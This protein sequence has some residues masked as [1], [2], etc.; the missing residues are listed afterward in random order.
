VIEGHTEGTFPNGFNCATLLSDEPSVFVQ[1][2]V[3]R[4]M[5]LPMSLHDANVVLRQLATALMAVHDAGICHRDIKPENVM[6]RPDGLLKLIDFGLA[7]L[8][9]ASA[10]VVLTESGTVM[11][12][13]AYMA[14]EQL[15]G[16]E[17]DARSDIWSF[18]VLAEELVG[19][20]SHGSR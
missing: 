3:T 11:G 8:P 6:L 1:A 14:P 5:E 17:T 4:R 15:A 18:G 2:K 10:L 13:F 7:R 16:Q 9:E 19:R 20:L 12:A